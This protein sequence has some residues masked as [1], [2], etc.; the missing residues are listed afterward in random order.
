LRGD[1]IATSAVVM[2]RRA[3]LDRAGGHDE[4]LTGCEDYEL[5]LRLMRSHEVY[6]HGRGVALPADTPSERPASHDQ[7][8][9]ALES[10]AGSAATSRGTPAGWPPTR[11]TDNRDRSWSAADIVRHA[12]AF[13]EPA[14]HAALRA[15]VANLEGGSPSGGR[16]TRHGGRTAQ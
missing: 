9:M 10:C 4:R 2:Y 5:N 7:I 16:G 11:R 8:I 14:F 3:A 15:A 1:F 12:D 13:A 6:F